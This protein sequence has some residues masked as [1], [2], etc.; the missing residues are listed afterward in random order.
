MYNE[1]ECI[2]VLSNS[3]IA[4]QMIGYGL[5]S[6]DLKQCLSCIGELRK[7]GMADDSSTIR[8]ALYIAFHT[9]YGKCFV[10]TVGRK[11]KLERDNFIS[12]IYRKA[13]EKI[14]ILRHSYTAH[15]GGYEE[16][17]VAA[18]GLDPDLS[19]KRVLDVA[20]PVVL[21]VSHIAERDMNIYERLIQEVLMK[22]EKKIEESRK[23]LRSEV[24]EG[25]IEKLYQIALKS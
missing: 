19:N 17:G 10:S 22:V 6:K 16:R 20:R 21:F 3:K 7:I 24:M 9:T 4:K 15:A 1:I 11:I 8:W 12:E 18:I 25:D 14:M 5:I 2:T 23:R 13:H